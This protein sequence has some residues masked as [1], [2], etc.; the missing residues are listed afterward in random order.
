MTLPYAYSLSTA[1]LLL[2]P[3][4]RADAA[5]IQQRFPHWE[6][7][8]YLNHKVP[9]PYPDNGARDF[10]EQTIEPEVNA[11][12]MWAWS[13]REKHAPDTLIGVITLTLSATEN[14]GL[15]VAPQWQGKGYATEACDAVTEFWFTTL[16]QPRLITRKCSA[17]LASRKL[18]QHHGMRL[19]EQ[20]LA[21]YVSGPQ[22]PTDI[23]EISREE[24]QRWQ[25]N[26][27]TP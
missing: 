14:R 20:T 2:R 21:D 12:S 15:W 24:W 19:V 9:W 25:G 22:Q 6:V 5:Q 27:V 11:H 10:I 18:S 3:L 1:R 26:S 23:W 7:V 13:M 8:K 4:E 16:K 17:N